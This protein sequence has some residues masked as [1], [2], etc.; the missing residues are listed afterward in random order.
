MKFFDKY[1]VRG[2][3]FAALG[4][5]G[6]IYNFVFVRFKEI[7]LIV[8]YSVVVLIGVMLLFFIKGRDS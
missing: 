3:V 4:M 7:F 8:G 5:A 1:S 6:V 2:I